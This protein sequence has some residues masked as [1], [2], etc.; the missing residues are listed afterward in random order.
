MN[1][2]KK[3]F[4]VFSFTCM[5]CIA[6]HSCGVGQKKL[7][8]AESRINSLMEKGVPDSLL[9]SAKVF[10]FQAKSA[11]K[12]SNT[13]YAR[14]YTD[15]LIFYLENAEAV[16]E[17]AVQKL[18]PDV[19]KMQAS[20]N[21]RKKELTGL[22]LQYADSI[23]AFI[24][25]FVNMNWLRQANDKCVFLDT[26]FPRLLEDEKNANKIRPKL[27]GNW[28]SEMVPQGGY[29]AKE[30]RK[31]S[32]K[33]DGSFHTIEQMRGQTSEYV[34]EDWKFLTWGKWKMKGDT[35][36]MFVEREKCAKQVYH[37]YKKNKKG[38]MV[39]EKNEA[40]TY[41]TTITDHKKDRFVTYE[42]MRDYF[43]RK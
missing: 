28:F 41:D 3:F 6:F 31:F 26:L 4:L 32:F 38:R 43:K 22:Q 25:S 8:D 19:E 21:K 13:A 40:P 2:F 33:K 1:F 34:K 30:T 20:L 14:M 10:L 15:S 39:W 29:K 37:N 11:K 5:L 35:V 12:T 17:S 42:Y 16:Y 27:V 18:K 36:L 23:I 7:E 24:D 9:S